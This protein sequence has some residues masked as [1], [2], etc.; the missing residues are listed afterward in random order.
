MQTTDTT[1]SRTDA[2]A[3][4]LRRLLNEGTLA[5]L[6]GMGSRA[7][8]LDALA[9]SQPASAAEVAKASGADV[10]R[11][12]AWLGALVAGRLVEYDGARDT[13]ALP[14]ELTELRRDPRGQ[15]YERGL[16]ALGVTE[17]PRG[18]D[19]A[20]VLGELLALRAGARL[21]LVL[22]LDGRALA[23][24]ADDVAGALAPG[25]AVIAAVSALSG[26]L[27]DD[28]LHPL[29]A[30]L[31]GAAAPG[32]A[33]AE[34]LGARLAAAGLEVGALARVPSDPFRNYLIA[35][36]PASTNR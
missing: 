36:K 4:R 17:G 27:A 5:L 22:A 14:A 28:A 21:D 1:T 16:A 20:P 11:V 6:V 12:R 15:A 19:P 33:S 23:A 10:E 29:G 7:G 9:A 31:H 34:R 2:I 30:Y 35:T 26:N 32:G 3:G 25:G 24:A 13:Y 18:A 8:W